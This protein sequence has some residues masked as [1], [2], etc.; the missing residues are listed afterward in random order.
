MFLKIIEIPRL[1]HFLFKTSSQELDYHVEELLKKTYKGVSSNF[2]QVPPK[3][4]V[5]LNEILY[6]LKERFKKFLGS[7]PLPFYII[8]SK[9]RDFSEKPQHVRAGKI[10][11]Q[12]NLKKE[13]LQEFEGVNL[14]YKVQD[15]LDDW[16]ELTL[17]ATVD[18]KIDF[19]YKDFFFT[20]PNPPCFFCGSTHH[21]YHKCPGLLEPQPR[22]V[23]EQALD[24]PF[25]E[26]SQIIWQGLIEEK[27]NYFNIRHFYLL[28]EFLKIVFYRGE[29]LTSWSQLKLSIETP[30]RGGN[31]GIGLDALIKGD[32][33]VAESRFL[34]EESDLKAC[35]GLTFVNLLKNR[36]DRALYFLETALSQNTSN[37]TKSYIIFLKGYLYEYQGNDLTAKELYQKAFELD[38]TFLPVFFRLRVL[39]YLNDE[40]IDKFMGYFGHPLLIFWAF[41]E[42]LFI[43]DQEE[44]ENFIEKRILEKRENALQ[45][46]KEAEDLFHRLKHVMTKDEIKEYEELLKTLA[47]DIYHR[48]MGAIDKASDRALDLTLELQAL[49]YNK[50]KEINH[51]ITE[52]KKQYEVL[53][54]F[55]SKYP[56]KEEDIIFGKELKTLKNLLEKN[57]ENTK[58]RDISQILTLMFS[59]LNLAEEKVQLLKDLKD[60]LKRKWVFRRRLTDFLRNFLLLETLLVT[61]YV[62]GYLFEDS[63]LESLLTIPVFLIISVVI[64]F[65]CLIL[66]YTKN[67]E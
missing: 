51:K 22:S 9:E 21:P 47:Y 37:F 33:N 5:Y 40:P 14:F 6:N 38:K 32:L 17:P 63:F 52:L 35:I 53:A 16:K 26:T 66:A 48:G 57:L 3:N 43:R 56:Y 58:K 12:E 19:F 15:W 45:R 64:L 34:E 62:I 30:V 42:P 59:E 65:L 36:W 8:L 24:L 50:V 54:T 28:P 2:Y 27:P 31:I 55:W 23:L 61:F 60:D 11:F 29:G 7:S 44:L 1:K 20:G 49:V 25:S 18:P 41:T 46:L 67:P 10:Y 39:D 13:V 4:L